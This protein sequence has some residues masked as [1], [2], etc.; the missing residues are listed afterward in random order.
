LLQPAYPA[1]NIAPLPQLEP[2]LLPPITPPTVVG[3]GAIR[4]AAIPIQANDLRAPPVIITPKMGL[5]E[6]Y[7][8]NPRNTPQTFSD[9]ITTISP[10]TAISFDTAR[11]QGQLN[12]SFNF[13]KY[14]RA[15]DQDNIT[16]DLLGFGLGT[17]VRDH[18]FVDGRAEL[19]PVSGTGGFGF[20]SSNLIPPSQQTQAFLLSISPIIRESIGSLLD[21][22]FRYN[23]SL[24]MFQNGGLFGTS[25]P[26]SGASVLTS[27]SNSSQN[28]ATL[29]LATGSRFAVLG[30][31]LTLDVLQVSPQSTQVSSQSVSSE[32]TQIRG[33]D[34]LQYQ[35]NSQFAAMARLGYEDIQYP[36]QSTANVHGAIYKIGGTYIPFPGSHLHIDYGRQDGINGVNGD[37]SYQVTAATVLTASLTHSLQT[38]Q[39]QLVTNLN[40]A[41]LNANGV[42][43][44]RLTGA[45]IILANLEVPFLTNVAFRNDNAI[46][47]IQTN[48]GRDTYGFVGFLN[49]RTS[50]GAPPTTNGVA[51][52]SSGNDTAFGV[53]LTWN[54]L[55]RAD[56]TS[57]AAL[58]YAIEDVGHTNTLTG[59]WLLT[60]IVSEKLTASLH[61]QLIN[62]STHLANTAY[63]RNQIEIGVRRTF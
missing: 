37:L 5:F 55:L 42:L 49:R 18:V 9:A 54:R 26:T 41:E 13:Q 12:G 35:V 34:D 56:L 50:T 11:L 59:D 43:V 48:I 31:K 24:N 3:L 36:N 4:P 23:Y 45:P 21:A 14:A 33:Y 38:S 39:Q 57:S 8:D 47:G 32:S 6:A 15:T 52:V 22:E 1:G 27:A 16:A 30:S 46:M 61:Y 29:T 19:T 62:V 44:S 17:V 28:E 53:N 25:T 2:F 7:T 60:Y 63:Y 51:G 40:N 10:A 58:G 20:A